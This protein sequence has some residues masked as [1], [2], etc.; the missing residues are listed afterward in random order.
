MHFSIMQ[1]YMFN[2]GKTLLIHS[3]FNKTV[4]YFPPGEGVAS[5]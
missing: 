3:N 1:I 2:Q 5:L 4:L